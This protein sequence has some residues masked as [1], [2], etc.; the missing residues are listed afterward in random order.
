MNR[1]Q[2]KLKKFYQELAVW[3]NSG[4]PEHKVFYK[5]AALCYQLSRWCG[6]FP[7]YARIYYNAPY[8]RH[9]QAELLYSGYGTQI[10]PFGANRYEIEVEIGN[11]YTNQE[12]LAFIFEQAGMKQENK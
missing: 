12:R 1:N 10:F 5:G 6:E 3:I 11:H 7:W 2:K 4:M 8:I 9:L